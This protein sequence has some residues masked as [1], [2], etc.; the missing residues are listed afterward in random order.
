MRRFASVMVFALSLGLLVGQ[1]DITAA[2]VPSG[3]TGPDWPVSPVEVNVD[4]KFIGMDV[5]PIED[6]N[7]LFIPIRAL[8]SLGLSYS[9]NATSKI[10]TVQNKN[11][12]YLK[13][14]VNSKI[15]YKNE[16]RIEMEMPAKNKDGRVLVPV[17]FVTE[18]L[19]YNVQYE[20]IRNIVFIT[21]KDYKFDASV[22]EQEDLQAARKAAIS[23]PV[24]S[25]FKK[26]GFKTYKDHMYMFPGG[27]ATTYIF[28]DEYTISVVE[29]KDGM[30]TLA[31]QF[32]R[33]ARGGDNIYW[34][35][36]VVEYSHP[37][38]KPFTELYAKFTKEDNEI[39]SYY[40]ENGRE[41]GSFKSPVETKVYSE[42]IQSVPDNI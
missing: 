30:A 27:K 16:Q 33:D 40:Y 37:T 7:R 39:T 6:T 3:F 41:K 25:D 20:S 10:T 14:T 23:L 13:L 11:G 17:R 36:T 32:V 19:G 42:I 4:G 21:S 31:G 35:G 9:W 38:L 5:S 22:L 15:A 8:A 2:T 26:L 18:S 24:T 28:H 1:S 34:A 29:I 12:D